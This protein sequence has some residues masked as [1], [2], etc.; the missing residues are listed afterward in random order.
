MYQ[1]LYVT[2]IFILYK[3]G[4]NYGDNY[5]HL[6]G[7]SPFSLYFVITKTL[8]LSHDKWKLV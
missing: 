7:F 5:S 3:I 1:S 8:N 4:E 6:W 2:M